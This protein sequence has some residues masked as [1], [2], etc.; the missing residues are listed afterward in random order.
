M[1]EP[2]VYR[3]G[4]TILPLFLWALMTGGAAIYSLQ[5]A[6]D[7]P[8]G[9]EARW[10]ALLIAVTG[11][12]FGPFAFLGHF[13]RFC[14]VTVS[15]DPEQGLCLSSGRKIAWREIRSVELGEA[16]FRGLIRPNPLIFITSAGCFAVLYYVVLPVCALFTPWHR[17]VILR[18]NDGE[19]LVLRDLMHAEEFIAE[20]MSHLQD[21]ASEG[22]GP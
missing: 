14:V 2:R 13:V 4:A 17:R 16:A 6:L 18:L 19:A 10:V 20:V 5:V 12:L 11:L 21:G 9:S 15:I 22:S 8:S 3:R 7:R 1:T